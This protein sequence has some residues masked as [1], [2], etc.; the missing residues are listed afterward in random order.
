MRHFWNSLAFLLAVAA[1]V[2]ATTALAG[3]GCC[4][5]CGCTA[6]CQKICRLV[7]EEKKVEVVCWGCECEDFCV[8]G[9]SKPGCTHCE[10]VCENCDCDSEV[11]SKSKRF[12]WSEWFP[13]RAKVFTK[14]K[15]MKKTVTVT[16][17]THRWVT[18]DV[19]GQC[20]AKGDGRL[21][22]TAVA[23]SA[24]NATFR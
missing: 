5:H 22:P 12:V 3:D 1:I 21:L 23:T 18:E 7:C 13:C 16:V 10:T 8:P 11:C 20:A 4:A 14:K 17:P 9:P 15:L 24:A 2:S 6:P 19:C